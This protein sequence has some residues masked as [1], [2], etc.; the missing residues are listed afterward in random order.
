MAKAISVNAYAKERGISHEAVRQA[1]KSGR[2]KA[3][4]V[5]ENGKPKIA[6]PDLAD[7]EWAENTDQSKPRN[8]ITGDPKHRRAPGEQMKPMSMESGEI[9]PARGRSGPS[10]TT[11]RAIREAYMARLAKLEFEEKAGKLVNA[12]EV[13]LAI[14]N[15]ARAARD[16]LMGLPHRVAP[17]ILGITDQHEAIRILTDEMRRAAAE[18]AKIKLPGDVQQ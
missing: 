6:D 13:R 11:S 2:L 4:V 3:S 10:Y 7:R 5:Y 15:A 12:D 17:L 9:D 8:R 1:I 14:F 16:I 18:L